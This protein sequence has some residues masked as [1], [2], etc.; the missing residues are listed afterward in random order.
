MLGFAVEDKPTKA[1]LKRAFRK[2]AL[3]VHPDVSSDGGSG[4]EFRAILEAF[5]LLTEDCD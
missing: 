3:L 2:A 5:E 4:E 1:E